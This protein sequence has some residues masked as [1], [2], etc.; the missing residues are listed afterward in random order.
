MFDFD[1]TVRRMELLDKFVLVKDF[2]DNQEAID[3]EIVRVWTLKE[4]F[5]RYVPQ[6]QFSDYK[7]EQSELFNKKQEAI[8]KT[9]S[10]VSLLEG[11]I[12]SMV[13]I[14]DKVSE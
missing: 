6:S 12:K 8:D 10:E 5:D 1:E 14:V 13:G 4:E 11:K 2:K 9:N 3:K 7:H